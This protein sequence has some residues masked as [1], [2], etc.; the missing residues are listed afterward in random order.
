ML[1]L[2]SKRTS[3]LNENWIQTQE[4]L[5]EWDDATLAKTLEVDERIEKLQTYMS[6]SIS[7][8]E[9]RSS[10]L[11]KAFTELEELVVGRKPKLE[12][13][14]TEVERI[15]AE[16]GAVVQRFG[17]MEK[18]VS[19]LRRAAD[20]TDGADVESIASILSHA[21]ELSQSGAGD[22]L[23]KIN[24]HERLFA[25]LVDAFKVEDEALVFLVRVEFEE[26][27]VIRN[28]HLLVEDDD[29]KVLAKLGLSPGREQ[30]CCIS[31][32]QM[33]KSEFTWIC[34]N[35][36]KRQFSY[37]IRRNKWHIV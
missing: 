33:G 18:T 37:S 13:L 24:R 36:I 22:L 26:E 19:R 28:S 20:G 11:N 7:N 21:E 32:V 35:T 6:T 15:E 10:S 25:H 17:E 12:S 9:P 5:K 16:Y 29:G 1:S 2:A 8:F 31:M 34:Q 23:A 4:K 27:T 30:G 3:E 14:L